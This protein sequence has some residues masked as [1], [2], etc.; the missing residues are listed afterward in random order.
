MTY[1]ILTDSD[2]AWD[3]TEG[4]APYTVEAESPEEAV[5]KANELLVSDDPGMLVGGGIQWVIGVIQ[6]IGTTNVL[7][8]NN[9][10]TIE[11]FKPFE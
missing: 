11:E 6:A 5:L 8:E 9:K 4:G 3:D 1:Y 10:T 7:W 2:W